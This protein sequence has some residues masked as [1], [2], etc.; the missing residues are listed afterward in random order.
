MGLVQA[1]QGEGILLCL[2]HA[3]LVVV[4]D[5]EQ[6]VPGQIELP[7]GAGAQIRPDLTDRGKVPAGSGRNDQGGLVSGQGINIA[8]VCFDPVGFADALFPDVGIGVVCR[9]DCP[10]RI[11][12]G[13]L[14][15]HRLVFLGLGRDAVQDL[16][17]ALLSFPDSLVDFLVV[18]GRGHIV[19]KLHRSF[20][21][22]LGRGVEGLGFRFFRHHRLFIDGVSGRCRGAAP[23]PG[24]EE[25]DPGCQHKGRCRQGDGQGQGLSSAGPGCCLPSDL[26]HGKNGGLLLLGNVRIVLI[27]LPDLAALFLQHLSDRFRT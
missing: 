14:F 7:D 21:G 19:G 5:Q 22:A 2:D 15:R 16:P 11:F 13:R 26:L 10:C 24:P 27:G 3:G 25:T 23:H 6:S 4:A 20:P 18:F 17:G 1:G 9:R 8:A 12:N